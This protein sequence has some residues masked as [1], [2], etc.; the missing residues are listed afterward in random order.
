MMRRRI[1]N[2]K[3]PKRDT[4]GL[5][6]KKHPEVIVPPGTDDETA[7][8]MVVASWLRRTGER[9][10]LRQ[11]TNGKSH[12]EIEAILCG[13]GLSH[14]LEPV[15]RAYAVEQGVALLP[16]LVA[17]A[18]EANSAALRVLSVLAFFKLLRIVN[19]E[20]SNSQPDL[21]DGVAHAL[22]PDL[23]EQLRV[24]DV[25]PEESTTS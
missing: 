12:E 15:I 9:A 19:N 21:L 3:Q 10:Q 18:R 1:K 5:S 17:S 16:F 13:E 22:L 4:K 7:V 6:V 24:K 2:K 8:L 23:L 25:R 11:N 14:R 20:E